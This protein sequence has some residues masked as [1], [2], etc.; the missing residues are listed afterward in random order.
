MWGHRVYTE[1]QQHNQ[2]HRKNTE[3]KQNT[4]I[5]STLAW[6]VHFRCHCVPCLFPYCFFSVVCLF[7]CRFLFLCCFHFVFTWTCACFV[8]FECFVFF[9]MIFLIPTQM[10][11]CDGL[12]IMTIWVSVWELDSA[13]IW[14]LEAFWM[15]VYKSSH[16][17]SRELVWPILE[18]LK[19]TNFIHSIF[20]VPHVRPISIFDRGLFA[21][22]VVVANQTQCQACRRDSPPPPA[23][24]SLRCSPR[25]S[26]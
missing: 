24:Y 13:S 11:D 5:Q 4:N 22:L 20:G 10:Q 21:I 3:K 18:A 16:G 12:C 17:L 19:A 9:T 1:K 23:L 25:N 14:H 8:V 2:K 6:L 15:I 7:L 26:S